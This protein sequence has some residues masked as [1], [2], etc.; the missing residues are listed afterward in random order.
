MTTDLNS[1]LDETR[2]QV[3]K[4]IELVEKK[5]TTGGEAA[6]DADVALGPEFKP[7]DAVYYG[8][9]GDITEFNNSHKR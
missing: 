5:N 4:T 9:I 7:Y 6:D 8:A 3:D 2:K 1:E